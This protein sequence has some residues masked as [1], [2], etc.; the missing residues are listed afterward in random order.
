[1]KHNLL[2]AISILV[3]ISCGS[4][5]AS[6]QENLKIGVL[7]TQKCLTEFYKSKEETTK[8]ENLIKE[9]NKEINERSADYQN[10]NTV[11]AEEEKKARSSELTPDARQAATQRIKEL[12]QERTMQLR[13]IEEL[14]RK[15]QEQLNSSQDEARKKLY[16]ELKAVVAEVSKAEGLDLVQDRSFLYISDKVTD[17]TEQVIAKMNANAPSKTAKGDAKQ[18]NRK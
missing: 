6:A 4:F 2:Q 5:T 18:N 12:L 8:I 16:A 9:K 13:E 14:K 10:L 17:I 11:L 7:D 15:I 1:M 3:I